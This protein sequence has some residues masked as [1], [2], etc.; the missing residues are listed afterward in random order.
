[1]KE[2]LGVILTP[3]TDGSWRKKLVYETIHFS[4]SSFTAIPRTPQ[5]CVQKTRAFLFSSHLIITP[6][7]GFRGCPLNPWGNKKGGPAWSGP[8]F[9]SILRSGLP[10]DSSRATSLLLNRKKPI[11]HP[12]KPKNPRKTAFFVKNTGIKFEKSL[13]NAA[14]HRL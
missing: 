5:E 14:I 12:Q 8:P 2:R 6:F 7:W 1:M 3:S 9:D 11:P 13:D 4:L 10:F